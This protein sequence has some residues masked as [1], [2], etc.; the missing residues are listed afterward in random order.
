MLGCTKEVHKT[1]RTPIA[2]Q[3]TASRWLEIDAY[4]CSWNVSASQAFCLSIT[5]WIMFL[6]S[7]VRCVRSG[8]GA[9]LG[10]A[11][12]ISVF[13]TG[14]MRVFFTSDNTN[15]EDAS[16]VTLPILLAPVMVSSLLRNFPL[17]W[18]FR[19]SHFATLNSMANSTADQ[20]KLAWSKRHFNQQTTVFEWMDTFF[21]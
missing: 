10:Y 6:S 8:F 2:E 7:S 15:L 19:P 4:L 3:I 17:A 16:C 11:V 13:R 14:N 12:D 5:D 9:G 20:A 18:T 21:I 1:A